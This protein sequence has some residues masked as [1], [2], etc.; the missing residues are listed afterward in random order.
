[1]SDSPGTAGRGATSGPETTA[2]TRPAAAVTL[3]QLS[4]EELVALG[5]GARHAVP[6]SSHGKWAAPANRADP[7]ALLEEQAESRVPELVSIRHGRMLISPFTFYRGNA[8][9][10]AADLASTPRSGLNVQTCGDTHLSNFGV[11]AS[12]ERDMLFDINDFD[13][14]LPGPWEW[15]LKRLAASF[16]I[17]GRDW[18][19]APDARREIVTACVREYR[20]VMRQAASIG[21]LDAWYAHMRAG[22]L[23]EWVQQEVRENRLSKKEARRADEDIATARTRDSARVVAKRADT[24]G[25]ELEIVAEPPLIERMAG[26]V[27]PGTEWEHMAETIERLLGA[28]RRTLA[29]QQH[30]VQRYRYVD[31][32]CKVVGVG[33]VGTRCYILLMLGRDDQDLL[34]LQVKEAQASVLERYVGASAY[35]N[36]G[37]RA[38]WPGSAC[39]RPGATSSWDGCASAA[40]MARPATTTCASST[41]GRAPRRW[42]GCSSP[43]R[44]STHACAV[45]RWPAPTRAGG[46]ESPSPPTLVTAMSSSRRSR[47]SPSR[48]PTRTSVTTMRLPRRSARGGL[49]QRRACDEPQDS[50]HPRCGAMTISMSA[51]PRASRSPGVVAVLV[52]PD[53]PTRS[54]SG[55]GQ[56]PQR[57]SMG[58]IGDQSE[59]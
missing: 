55:A 20:D 35:P 56:A 10:M 21:H 47:D 27:R 5:K 6:R 19:F 17:A 9:I 30:P 11:F 1:M 12:P 43:V 57:A 45:Q 58:R 37:Q 52:M 32:A 25:G 42:I 14:T 29:Q 18:G 3:T 22:Q 36:H 13:E 28:Y 24:I 44:R 51:G 31:A 49:P 33:S 26:L 46:T 15:D 39:C 40:S 38:S 2:R 23:I 41:T 59:C 54:W 53:A 34:F 4:P 8:L 48:T 50:R 16:E 7:V